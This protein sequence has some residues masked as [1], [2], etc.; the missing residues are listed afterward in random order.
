MASLPYCQFESNASLPLILN[1]N[2]GNIIPH[3]WYRLITSESGK[4]DYN[5]ITIF[6]E[7]VYWYRPNRV[8]AKKFPT[9]AWQTSYEHFEKK[10]NYNKQKVRR[11]LVRLEELGF[12]K[13]ELR[14]IEKL[15]QRYGNVLFIHLNK[16]ALEDKKISHSDFKF[17]TPSIQICREHYKEEEIKKENKEE[18]RSTKSNFLNEAF[19]SSENLPNLVME[20]A[21]V[22]VMIDQHFTP[23]KGKTLL[24]FYPLSTEDSN[25]LRTKSGREFD[26]NFINQLLLKLSKKYPEHRF[27]RK[28]FFLNYL[29]K[30]LSNLS[31]SGASKN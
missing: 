25:L 26:L 1:K 30:A 6:S 9:D 19:E 29:S 14:V 11:G 7:I 22:S 12:I 2:I 27:S 8:G 23:S 31:L 13:R 3:S 21:N 10:F 15:G 28:E 5:A 18:S 24:D 17:D 4:P 16:N 20:K